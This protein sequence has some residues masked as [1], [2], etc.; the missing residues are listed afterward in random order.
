MLGGAGLRSCR[1]FPWWYHQPGWRPVL[2]HLVTCSLMWTDVGRAFSP[3]REAGVWGSLVTKLN[4]HCLLPGPHLGC[5]PQPFPLEAVSLLPHRPRG[6]RG[7]L[8]GVSHSWGPVG[9]AAYEHG[10]LSSVVW[11]LVL[12][13]SAAALRGFQGHGPLLH[14]RSGYAY[15]LLQ[16]LLILQLWGGTAGERVRP[17]SRPHRPP[18]H[19]TCCSVAWLAFQGLSV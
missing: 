1:P 6:L 12:L 10:A 16:G 17:P 4:V 9:R 5:S 14:G 3:G 15:D 2:V 7:H 18:A 19:S 8:P 11:E 13:G